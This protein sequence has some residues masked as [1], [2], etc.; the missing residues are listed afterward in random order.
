MFDSIFEQYNGKNICKWQEALDIIPMI[1]REMMALGI[2]YENKNNMRCYNKKWMPEKYR[3]YNG[4]AI[5]ESNV[6]NVI[7]AVR[8]IK[9]CDEEA[10]LI[11]CNLAIF[12]DVSSPEMYIKRIKKVIN[13]TKAKC[14]REWS[15]HM[16]ALVSRLET[17][18]FCP[19]NTPDHNPAI[20][21]QI[22]SNFDF[23]NYYYSTPDE[24]EA[25]VDA[26]F[27]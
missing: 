10:G 15:A 19:G 21:N 8:D 14:N 17:A 11:P 23:D 2:T 13:H 6:Y 3:D 4:E 9:Q 5:K 1:N 22:R 12:H 25:Y 26:Y 16:D 24:M 27:E 18:I 7:N 20:L